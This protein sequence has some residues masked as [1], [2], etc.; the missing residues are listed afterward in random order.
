[1]KKIAMIYLDMDGVL[2]DFDRAFIEIY[3]AKP[4]D[5][6]KQHGTARFWEAVYQDPNFFSKL[7]RFVHT[8]E[9]VRTCAFMADVCILSSPSKVNTPLC[10]IQKRQW[11]D[12]NI[13]RDFPAIF[14]GNKHLYA[15]ADRV[16][17]DDTPG[18][19]Q[20]FTQAG[21]IGHLF[22]GWDACKEFLEGLR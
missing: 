3:G 17:I 6:E 8:P 18:K 21:G 19:I 11:I 1:M 10:M 4:D 2:A 20:A 15:A 14:D 13:Y 9:L 5:Y 12:R 7:P 22:T 16:L